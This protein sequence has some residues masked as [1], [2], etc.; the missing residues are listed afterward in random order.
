MPRSL[1]FCAPG[2]RLSGRLM[3]DYR[4]TAEER[5][6]FKRCRRQWDFASSHRRNLQPAGRVSSQASRSAATDRIQQLTAGV[7]RR[8]RIRRSRHEITSAGPLI[9]AEAIDMA[10]SP[11]VYPTF[12]AHCGA[13]EF[14]APCSALTAGV[15]AEPLLEA[16]FRRPPDQQPKPQLGQSTW[17]FGRGAAPPRW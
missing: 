13:C 4:I 9:A 11:S 12:A 17:G 1:Q 2:S 3:V 6:R 16:D 8:T 7:L 5:I 14:S 15:D 10:S